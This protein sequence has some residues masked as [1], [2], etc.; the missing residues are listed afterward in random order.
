MV[1]CCEM[2]HKELLERHALSYGDRACPLVMTQLTLTYFLSFPSPCQ[3]LHDPDATG[4]LRAAHDYAGVLLERNLDQ[5]LVR[6]H[7][8][9][10][11]IHPERDLA[12]EQRCPQVGR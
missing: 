10:L 6:C 1:E 9:P 5:R 3:A 11:D 8:I 4:L 2:M 12:G 7:A